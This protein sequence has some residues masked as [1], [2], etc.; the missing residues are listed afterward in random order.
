MIKSIRVIVASMSLCALVIQGGPAAAWTEGYTEVP[1]SSKGINNTR[2]LELIANAE[3]ANG[4]VTM[5][6]LINNT[7]TWQLVAN[8][9]NGSAS[10]LTALLNASGSI[11][12]GC[13]VADHGENDGEENGQCIVSNS[14][15]ATRA[16]ELYVWAD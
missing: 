5:S 14:N 9:I 6:S 12:P 8:Y 1:N 7:A 13:S 16:V 3:S 2:S 15:A 10:S 4:R 11:I